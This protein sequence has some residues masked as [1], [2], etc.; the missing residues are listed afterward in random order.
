MSIEKLGRG[1]YSVSGK[2]INIQCPHCKDV[3]RHMPQ[4]TEHVQRPACIRCHKSH[5][6]VPGFY[7]SRIGNFTGIVFVIRH[8]RDDAYIAR[9]WLRGIKRWTKERVIYLFQVV[10][11]TSN[12][13]VAEV[14]G[15]SIAE[16][17]D[18]GNFNY[19]PEGGAA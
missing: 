14:V 11:S 4:A 17:A 18:N 12:L 8:E 16:A 13:K 3:T 10:E 15:Y 5:T 1:V 19:H 6:L 2:T 7:W 9:R